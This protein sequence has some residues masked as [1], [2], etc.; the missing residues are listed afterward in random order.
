MLVSKQY[1]TQVEL[2]AYI[3]LNALL[4]CPR[5]C[6]PALKVQVRYTVP[7]MGDGYRAVG[8]SG[9]RTAQPDPSYRHSPTSYVHERLDEGAPDPLYRTTRGRWLS[10]S[11]GE[12]P[13]TEVTS[14][15]PSAPRQKPL[16]GMCSHHIVD[17]IRVAAMDS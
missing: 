7:L 15:T 2:Q 16:R 3:L 13:G 5:P 1:S 6:V 12:R 14:R 4:P 17:P 10:G 8:V 9:L 11:G